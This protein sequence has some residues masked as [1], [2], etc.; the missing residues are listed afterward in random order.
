MFLNDVKRIV[1]TGFALLALYGLFYKHTLHW[2]NW[3]VPIFAA[4][5]YFYVDM[6]FSDKAFML[7]HACTTSLLIMAYK[8]DLNVPLLLCLMNQASSTLVLNLSYYAPVQYKPGM[9]LVFAA[10]FAKVRVYDFYWAL[11]DPR[12]FEDSL[13]FHAYVKG[14]ACML[15]FI[16]V[17]WAVLILK[18]I[19]GPRF[20]GKY[21]NLNVCMSTLTIP[22]LCAA[23]CVKLPV[24]A[25]NVFLTA[26]QYKKHAHYSAGVVY[27][28]LRM[29]ACMYN[30]SS[31]PVFAASL[32]L[33]GASVLALKKCTLLQTTYFSIAA[34]LALL[35][36]Q[37]TLDYVLINY[38]A[39]LVMQMKPLNKLSYALF[40]VLYLPQLYLSA[41]K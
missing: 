23:G 14:V 33:H 17:Y 6:M 35:G 2:E 21:K 27:I 24:L 22:V 19:V 9:Q 15:Y 28:H 12:T 1:N 34:D 11:R 32:L 20:T 29:L 25:T 10:V 40:H 39:A 8:V 5:V 38:L 13:A 16:N 30:M 3:N 18:K 26:Y 36:P 7:H 41:K 31:A 4:T 37:L